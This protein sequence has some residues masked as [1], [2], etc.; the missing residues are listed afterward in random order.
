[1]Y[2]NKR[3]TADLD[4]PLNDKV[5]LRVNG[6]FENSD[7]FRD[8]VGLE[9]Y[10]V[11]AD[12][13][14]LRRATA[15]R[16]RCATSTCTTRA[17][18]I[19][20]SRRSRAG[21]PTSTVATFYGN[22]DA[23]DVAGRG[24]HRQRRPIEH[25]RRRV[26]R[27]ATARWSATTIAST[28]TSCPGAVDRR[29]D[30]GGAHGLQQR[31]RAAQRLQPDRRHVRGFHRARPAH[32][33]RRRR[34]RPPADRQLPEHRL[35]QQHRDVDPGAV[36]RTR[37][38]ATPVTFRQN[39]TDADNHVTHERGG[40]LRP[41]S[42][43]AV[44]RTSR[45]SPACA[46]TGSTSRTTTTATATRWTAPTISSRRAPASS[47]ADRAGVGLRQLQR[48]V[49]SEL[50]RSVLV[51]DG[52]HRAGQAGAVPQLRG[53]REVGRR[54]RPVGDDRGIPPRT[55]PTRARPIP[56]IR[57]ASCRRAA[58][59]PTATN[60]ASTGRSCRAWN[61]AGGYAYQDAFVTSATTAARRRRAG[62]ARCRITRCR[63]GTTTRSTRA[64]R[65]GLGVLYRTDMF[66][67][68][69]NTV[70]PAGLHAR[71]RGGVR[72]RSR[73]SCALQVNVENLFD[74]AYFINADSNTNISPGFPRALR[75]GL[76]AAF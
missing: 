6:M 44:A 59:A 3:F 39:A 17:S 27:S 63:C 20:A 51:A 13:D 46:S 41:G 42:D 65:R 53:R 7:S 75:V 54:R 58:S 74:K 50:G 40:R 28:R 18:P 10:G 36:R 56:T 52:D 9:R 1:M 21:R 24:Q 61:V 29:P 47:Q 23:S 19:A 64:W 67:A 62:R 33:A 32:A 45:C 16:S 69:D 4:Q 38:S 5:A 35:L 68:I 8:V 15:R 11:D 71:G 26:S 73:R 49:S 48:V 66:A 72:R 37:R 70:D 34:V 14:D 55:A 60:S 76:T 31:D 22:P 12:G 30:A 43:R 57:R 25:Q 2:G